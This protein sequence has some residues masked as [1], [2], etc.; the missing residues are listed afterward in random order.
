MAKEC[1]SC[2]RSF[3][4]KLSHCPYDGAP[5]VR[6]FIPS[7]DPYL[8]LWLENKYHIEAKLGEGGMCDIY[9]ARIIANGQPCAVKIL[10]RTLAS[11]GPS[12]KRFKHEMRAASLI[13]HPNVV[14]LI[15]SGETDDGIVYMVM[16]LLEGITLKQ[17]IQREGGFAI[18]RIHG[19]IKQ[20]CEALEAA[21]SQGVI[22]RDLKPDNIML[23]NRG[24]PL[25]EVVKVLDFGIAKVRSELSNTGEL[26]SPHMVMGTPRYMSPEQCQGYTIDARSD[27]YSLGVI[28]YEMFAG[29]PPFTDSSARVLMNKHTQEPVPNLKQWRPDLSSVVER[30]VLHALEKSPLKRPQSARDFADE[31]E[32]AINSDP[33]VSPETAVEQPQPVVKS[34][35][36]PVVK[37]VSGSVSIVEYIAQPQLPE[38]TKA[39]NPLLSSGQIKTHLQKSW[40]Y[41]F[42]GLVL[43]LLVIIIVLFIFIV[44]SDPHRASLYP[45]PSIGIGK[46]AQSSNFS[47]SLG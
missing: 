8:G 41:W 36:V 25:Q 1:T 38:R 15:D 29:V 27:I 9:R 39:N 5:L 42:I 6:S 37:Q 28:V 4:D 11:D 23:L 47:N 16:E 46:L 13:K 35:L 21:H 18:E 7:K 2:H 34:N 19:I 12:V 43:A 26:V 24:E 40:P 30:V 14:D 17:V 3:K 22:H 33:S 20:I 45:L 31:M 32:A 10:H 44:S